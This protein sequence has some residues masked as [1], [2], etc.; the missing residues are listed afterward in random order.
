MDLTVAR[1]AG[2]VFFLAL[3]LAC[4]MRLVDRATPGPALILVADVAMLLTFRADVALVA[5]GGLAAGLILGRRRIVGALFTGALVVGMVAILVGGVGLGRSGYRASTALSL[6][7]VSL[8]RADL[9]GTSGSGFAR[10]A[11]VSTPSRAISYLPRGLPSFLFGPFP[12]E[13]RN[14]RQLFGWL[15]ALTV[16]GMAPWAWHGWRL[17]RRQLGRKRLVFVLPAASLAISL[18]LLIGNYG[19]V[20]RE[21]LQVLV[22]V[23]PLAAVGLS[24]RQARRRGEVHPLGAAEPALLPRSV[25]RLTGL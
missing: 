16:L 4:T 7:D 9:A 19:T 18:T 8:A 15:E 24:T 12:W 14:V 13:I 2:V 23:I 22:F 20:V 3:G 17:A 11:D 21:R 6:R 25:G 5:A 1:E 10:T